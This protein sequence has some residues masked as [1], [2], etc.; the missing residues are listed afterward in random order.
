[1][2]DSQRKSMFSRQE[3]RESVFCKEMH[4]Q[5]GLQERAGYQEKLQ[6]GECQQVSWKKGVGEEPYWP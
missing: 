2:S 3:G 1:M 4:G 6:Q 5:A